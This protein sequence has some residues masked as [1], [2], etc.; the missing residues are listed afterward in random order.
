MAPSISTLLLNAP[1]RALCLKMAAAQS[2]PECG[3]SNIIDDSHHSQAQLVCVD[4]G[5]VVSE[6]LLTTT[7]SE[8]QYHMTSH[9]NQHS[10]YSE[11]S[12]LGKQL[13]RNQNRS[14]SGAYSER[15][16]KEP[17]RNQIRGLQ[18]VSTLCHI[19]RFP[20]GVEDSSRS[21]FERA[22]RHPAFLGVSL[23]RKEVL[24]GCCVLL[25]GRQYSWPVTMGTISSLLQAN[26]GL[27]AGVYLELVEKLGVEAPPT[28][29]TQLVRSHC[30]SFQLSTASVPDQF[31]ECLSKLV[32]RASNLVELAGEAWIV[33]GRHPVPILTAAVYLSWLSLRPVAPRL[34]TSLSRFC[35]LA[36]V[37]LP[38][39]A[40]KRLAELQDALCKLG[41]ELPWLRG[42]KLDR[43][44]V[45]KHAGDILKHRAVLLRRAMESQGGEEVEDSEQAPQRTLGVA[46]QAA[47][48]TAHSGASLSLVGS[49]TQCAGCEDKELEGA[50]AAALNTG[51][52]EKGGCAQGSLSS[53]AGGSVVQCS[54]AEGSVKPAAMVPVKGTINSAQDLVETEGPGNCGTL[55]LPAGGKRRRPVFLPPCIVNPPKRRQ[56]DEEESRGR[57]VT[58]DEEIS[59]SEIE[60]YIRTPDEMRQFAETQSRLDECRAEVSRGT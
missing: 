44:V 47:C 17:C 39:P 59:D 37:P 46:E 54:S 49:V 57:E 9:S 42:V 60:Q 3:S 23:E 40:H 31:S 50:A 6:G 20:P 13:Y 29:I 53:P 8:E 21:L 18:R 45:A 41:K 10:G 30:S 32:D 36:G 22:Y 34:A 14:E 15:T 26:P 5:S 19:L 48:V 55:P 7:L 43:K 12:V 58:G 52:N 56:R 4:C 38:L 2:C 27:M 25:V 24:A 1:A 16:D 51:G 35:K 28:T 33:T 11:R